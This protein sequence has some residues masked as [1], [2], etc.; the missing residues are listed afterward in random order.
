[1]E[2]EEEIVFVPQKINKRKSVLIWVL[3][4]VLCLV[5]VVFFLYQR[6]VDQRFENLTATETDSMAEEPN[7]LASMDN[8]ETHK[9]GVF[10][11]PEYSKIPINF[12]RGIVKIFMDNGY[13]END[14]RAKYFFTK[15]ADRAE[16]V[17]AFGNFT[18]GEEL[19]MAFLL[20]K[21]DFESSA[22]FIISANGDLLFWKELHSE[23]PTINRF[24]QGSRIYMDETVLKP[25]PLDGLI[26][27][28]RGN[29][30]AYLYNQK[31]KT[32]DK[33]YQYTESEIKQMKEE[34]E[35]GDHYEEEGDDHVDSARNAG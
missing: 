8:Y 12:Q 1:M 7:G 20:E 35:Q 2:P 33:H 25:S 6:H 31:T 14:D 18:G 21:Q 34:Q 32:F 10:T 13:F 19:E 26:S 24:K 9:N 27:Q 23:L 30:Y 16:K 3:S 29:K 11:I 22:L 15:I 17:Y 4:I 5:V 28:N